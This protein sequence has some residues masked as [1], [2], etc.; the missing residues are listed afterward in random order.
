MEST[1]LSMACPGEERSWELR[2][3][4][5]TSPLADVSLTSSRASSVSRAPSRSLREEFLRTM[6]RRE[7]ERRRAGASEGTGS[8]PRGR[9]EGRRAGVGVVGILVTPS[10]RTV[11]RSSGRSLC[12]IQ[13]SEISTNLN[14]WMFF[15]YIE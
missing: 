1:D 4:G 5:V 2:L 11:V 14:V 12:P 10:S 8:G 7:N 3:D 13:P 9:E 6:V 15:W